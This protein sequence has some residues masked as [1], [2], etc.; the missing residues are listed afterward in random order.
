M[1]SEQAALF[2]FVE[3]P[4]FARFRDDYLDDDGL[5]CIESL[6]VGQDIYRAACVAHELF[7]M[8]AVDE[9]HWCSNYPDDDWSVPDLETLADHW[10][11][12]HAD[13]NEDQVREKAQSDHRWMSSRKEFQRN[14]Q[15]RVKAFAKTWSNLT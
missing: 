3:A 2:Q 10:R 7:G 11:S 14:T 12:H 4:A 1:N 8:S 6:A 15:E 5:L 13:W 9:A